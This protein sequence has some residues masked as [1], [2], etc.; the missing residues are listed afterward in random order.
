MVN[1]KSVYWE[2]RS[3]LHRMVSLLDILFVVLR[4]K[5]HLIGSKSDRV[6]VDTPVE[7]EPVQQKS[8]IIRAWMGRSVTCP[9]LSLRARLKH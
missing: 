2:T 3:R 9:V 7:H 6:D 4:T 1:A 5:R 8:Y